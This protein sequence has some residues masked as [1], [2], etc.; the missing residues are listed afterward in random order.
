MA[1][2]RPW[3][4]TY[5]H[6]YRNDVAERQSN[7]RKWFNNFTNWPISCVNF[8]HTRLPHQKLVFA[9]PA[10]DVVVCRSLFYLL[11]VESLYMVAS[12]KQR[13]SNGF[14]QTA[15]LYVKSRCMRSFIPD[16]CARR[17]RSIL[18]YYYY[19]AGAILLSAMTTRLFPVFR[20]SS[21][22]HWSILLSV[23]S[24]FRIHLPVRRWVDNFIR[25]SF[26]FLNDF[27]DQ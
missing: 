22:R 8:C 10:A 19:Y 3:F 12:C 11:L 13:P 15:F 5:D 2:N 20:S 1:I 16:D 9:N 4:Q 18:Y 21:A 25:S 23:S 27:L 26:L 6:D 17:L 7:R 24:C 14:G